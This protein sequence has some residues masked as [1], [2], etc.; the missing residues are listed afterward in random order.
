[1]RSRTVVVKV[2]SNV[3]AN[4]DGSLDHKVLESI[5]EQLSR[6]KELGA[7]VVLVS[8]GAVASGRSFLQNSFC[9][10][11][12]VERRQVLAAVG[13]VSLIAEYQRLFYEKGLYSA[14]ILA[15]KEDFRDRYHYLCMRS[16]IE[17]M[18]HERV[19]PIVN[20]NDVVAVD[21]LM[22][23]DNDELAGLLA[24]M[25]GA[26]DLYI[27]S[28][29]DGLFTADPKSADSR[30]IAVVE[31]G[32]RQWEKYTA[33]G[34]RSEFGRG[35]MHTKCRVASRMAELGIATFFANGRKE[36]MILSLF[37]RRE[38]CVSTY[39]VPAKKKSAVKKWI[40]HEKGRE[41]GVVLINPCAVQILRDN[42]KA[43]S[44][45]PVGITDVQ[46]NWEKG[47]I[48]CIRSEKL[49]LVGFGRA[50]YSAKVA[51][52]HIGKKGERP[53]VHY[54]YLYVEV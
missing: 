9:T 2:G 41:K 49:D 3:L 11:D 4:K 54:D 5:V 12:A 22:F 30:F 27:L 43:C 34:T 37:E 53:L 31:E 24:S 48:L 16:C 47:D 35:G 33:S 20:E 50:Q 10:G 46:G 52:E 17:A 51:K 39:F 32:C 23:T 36:Q 13:Q 44:L 28:S 14:Q 42:K 1:M 38:N 8:S 45:L 21:E 25:I 29:V 40:A 7:R 6:L 26:D 19:V 18:L 15:T